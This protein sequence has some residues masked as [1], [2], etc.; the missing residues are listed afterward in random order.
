VSFF[1]QN[2]NITSL[3]ARTICAKRV[4]FQSAHHQRSDSGLR[5]GQFR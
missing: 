4:I 3:Q 1:N 5:I 2:T